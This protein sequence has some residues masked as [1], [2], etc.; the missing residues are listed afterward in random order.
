MDIEFGFKVKARVAGRF[1]LD[2]EIEMEVEVLID[3]Q[4]QIE[5]ETD[6][7]NVFGEGGGD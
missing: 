5:I 2:G 6:M 7:E 3:N 1:E 4:M